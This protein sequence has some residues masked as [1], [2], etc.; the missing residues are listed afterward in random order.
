MREGHRDQVERTI[1]IGN[2]RARDQLV[3]T[4]PEVLK[5]LR[6][7]KCCSINSEEHLTILVVKQSRRAIDTGDPVLTS[8]SLN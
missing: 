2:V 1:K 6:G 5:F 3:L 7:A 4:G 8:G